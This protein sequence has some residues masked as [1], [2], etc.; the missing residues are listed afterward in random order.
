VFLNRGKVVVSLVMIPVIILY[1]FAD[2]ILIALDQDP[3]IAIIARRYCIVLIP[4][5]YAQSLFDATRK[6]LSAQFEIKMNLYI[7]LCTLILHFLWCYLFI[8]VFDW[9]EVGA[10]IATNITY[11]VNMICLDLYCYNSK[12][13]QRTHKLMPD[14]RSLENIG[15]YLAIGIPG[16]CMLCFEWWVFELLAVF[17]GLMSVEALGAEIIIV[18]IVSLIFMIPLG[19][20][21]AASAFTG[22]F[23]G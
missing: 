7:Q 6:F 13:M 12:K 16:A 17:S 11:I 20:G 1:F 18:N 2:K 21:Y 14:R 23:L 9:R 8:V 10:A 3:E 22:Y 15:T 5:I 4:G 19:T